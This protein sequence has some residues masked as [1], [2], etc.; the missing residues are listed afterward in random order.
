MKRKRRKNIH[1]GEV[2]FPRAGL[3]RGIVCVL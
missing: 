1:R 2:R 3:S